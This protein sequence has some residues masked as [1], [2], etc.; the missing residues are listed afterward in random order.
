MDTFQTQVL[1]RLARIETKLN[2]GIVK[3]QD[4][5]EKRIRYLERSLWIGVGV[6]LAAQVAIGLFIK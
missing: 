1:D 5:H 6:I 4:D 2:N 3:K